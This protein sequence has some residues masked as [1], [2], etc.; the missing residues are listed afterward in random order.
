M[1]IF[2]DSGLFELLIMIA[3]ASFLNFIFFRKYLL[4]FYSILVIVIPVCLFFINVGWFFDV[5]LIFTL[6]NCIIF[7]VLLWQAKHD[8]PTQKIIKSDALKN[9]FSKIFKW[10]KT[11]E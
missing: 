8:E 2:L 1:E 9:T 6:F 5:A 11:K 4:I 3:L 10:R 7:V